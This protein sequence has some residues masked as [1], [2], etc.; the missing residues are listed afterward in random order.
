MDSQGGAGRKR[1][2]D[3]EGVP[4][5][6]GVR[7]GS[8][9]LAPDTWPPRGHERASEGA[10]PL[11]AGGSR[12]RQRTPQRPCLKTSCGPTRRLDRASEKGAVTSSVQLV[13]RQRAPGRAGG[14]T[15]EGTGPCSG[16]AS[17]L[18]AADTPAP[19]GVRG[20]DST[21][22]SSAMGNSRH[23]RQLFSPDRDRIKTLSVRQQLGAWEAISGSPKKAAVAYLSTVFISGW[24][25]ERGFF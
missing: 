22:S 9:S 23:R 18:T 19:P 24:E 2:G 1:H 13:D 17:A 4:A 8:T 12:R 5:R 14:G 10:V 15:R 21:G 3:R 7:S 20:R 16:G 6:V 11:G 25:L